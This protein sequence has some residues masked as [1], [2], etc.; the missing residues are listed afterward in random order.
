M[1][2]TRSL[3]W[4]E[5]KIGLITVFAIFMTGLLI[6]L[7]SGQGGFPWQQYTVRTVFDDIAGLKAGAPVR[8]AGLEVGSVEALRFIPGSDRVEVVMT[9]SREMQS[10]ITS[11]SVASLGSISL[12]GEAAV[13]I[14]SSTSGTPIAE[15]G[16]VPSGRAAG[17]LTDVAAQAS[18]GIEELT[19]LLQDVR[20]GRGTV[21]KLFTEDTIALEVEALLRSLDG[22]ATQISSG[23]GTIGRLLNDPAAAQSL[24]ASLRD[25]QEITGRIRRGEGSLGRLMADDEFARTLT[26][27]TTN[28]DAFTGRLNR[29]EGTLGQLATNDE[30]F[31]RFNSA[32]G[33]L[34]A[35]FDGLQQGDGTAGMLLRDKQLYENMNA[36]MVELR[37]TLA[38][39][40]Q[41][42]TAIQNDPKRYLNIRVSLF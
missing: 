34:D 35:V 8:V 2:R 5:L 14:T 12:L 23:D 9:V 22:V 3:A 42:I 16:E 25:L 29:G 27:L 33:R 24:E 10:R 41:L 19:G 13:D 36:T 7:L 28:L 6:F 37:A 31:N 39:T 20:S 26:G 21:G 4:A 32:A 18:T 30:L 11:S 15:N 1:P 38:D 17:S 40:R